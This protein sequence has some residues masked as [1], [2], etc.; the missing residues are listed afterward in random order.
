MVYSN[1]GDRGCENLHDGRGEEEW[2]KYGSL[3]LLL[4]LVC[5]GGKMLFSCEKILSFESFEL[6]HV[7]FLLKM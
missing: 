4:F 5:F 7:F 1:F 6:W 3:L 2:D